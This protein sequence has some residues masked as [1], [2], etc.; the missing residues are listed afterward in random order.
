MAPVKIVPSEALPG[1]IVQMEPLQIL[2]AVKMVRQRGVVGVV[3][4]KMEAPRIKIVELVRLV[5]E[6]TRIH[7]FP[8]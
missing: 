4:A 1:K 8:G 2:V 7:P 3:I 6:P 5:H